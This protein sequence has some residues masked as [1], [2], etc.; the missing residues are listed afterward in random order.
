MKKKTFKNHFDKFPPI[1]REMVMQEMSDG[2]AES[3][4]SYISNPLACSGVFNNDEMFDFWEAVEADAIH[5]KVW[6][7]KK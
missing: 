2:L 4:S 7:D 6:E 3:P 1:L 5:H